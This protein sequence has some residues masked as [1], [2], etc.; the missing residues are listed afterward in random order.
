MTKE[1]SES[2]ES[3]LMVYATGS[4]GIGRAAF[5]KTFVAL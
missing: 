2:F 5:A 4:S 1:A 3:S